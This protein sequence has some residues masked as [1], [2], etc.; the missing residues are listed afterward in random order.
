MTITDPLYVNVL[1][2][3]RYAK[4]NL[5]P[6]CYKT[7]SLLHSKIQLLGSDNDEKNYDKWFVDLWSTLSKFK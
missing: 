3:R 5:V 6:L 7:L 4:Q 1:A 2:I